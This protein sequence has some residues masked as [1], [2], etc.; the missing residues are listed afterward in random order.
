MM[1]RRICSGPEP[2]EP[3]LCRPVRDLETDPPVDTSHLQGFRLPG[4]VDLHVHGGF[5]WDFSFGDPDRLDTMLDGFLQAGLTGVVAT[6]ITTSEEQRCRAL[7]DIATVA[8]R[9]RR[10]PAIMG[11]YLEGPF[12]APA[13]RGS[14]AA[15]LLRPPDLAAL[16]RWQELARGMIRFVTIAPEWPGA[17]DLIRPIQD[18]LKIRV[19]IGHTDADHATAVAAFEAGATHVTHLY[20]AMRPFTHRDPTAVSAVL[21]HRNVLVELIADGIHVCPEIIQMTFSLLGPER[22]SLIS[23]GVLPAGLPDGVYQAYGATLELTDGRC[24]FQGGHLFGGGRLLLECIPLLVERVR[25]PL[26]T[27]ASCLSFHPC[28]ALGLDLPPGDVLLDRQFRWLATRFGDQW[29]WAE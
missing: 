29:Y 28:H 4:I 22:I 13:R 8:A 17:I 14:H 3:I 11:I 24:T 23:D 6:L 15:D 2:P 10:P 7:V 1:I 18:E 16:R 12:L 27:I 20:N 26:R 25:L 5:G 9:R 21:R 19:A